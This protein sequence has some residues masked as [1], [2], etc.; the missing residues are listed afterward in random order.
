MLYRLFGFEHLKYDSLSIKSKNNKRLQML[1]ILMLC[2][3]TCSRDYRSY[4]FSLILYN[5]GILDGDLLNSA[6]LV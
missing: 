6:L 4:L 2:L 3:F 5:D 1:V